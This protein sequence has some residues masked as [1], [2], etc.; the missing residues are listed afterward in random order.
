ML[1][2]C[3]ERSTESKHPVFVALGKTIG[4]TGLPQQLFDDLITAFE[5][6]QVVTHHPT[7]ESLI[8]Y[9]KYSAN[10]VGRL[11]LWVSGYQDEERAQL[12][13]K[14]CT[15]LQLANFWQDVVEDWQRGRRYL[16]ADV[17]DHF[18]V[19]DETIANRNFTPQ[20]RDMMAFLVSY[21]G[22]MLADG[23]RISGRVD[24]ELAVTLKLFERGGRAALDGVIGQGY[25]VLKRRP[26][27]SKATKVKLLVGALA[28]K[29]GSALL[30]RGRAG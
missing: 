19:T 22:E 21:A 16:P 15:A 3:Y 30:G 18:G 8:D 27:V 1:T 14:V 2:E 23:G 12:S 11:V 29:A 28:G 17:M 9:S 4:E 26:S 6:D 10:P 13:D 5:R 20:F 7:L 25:D 24:R